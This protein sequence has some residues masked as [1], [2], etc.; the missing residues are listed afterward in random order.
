MLVAQ[1]NGFQICFSGK[2]SH[3]YIYLLLFNLIVV[4][5]V[6]NSNHGGHI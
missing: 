6:E 5:E 1:K 4:K 2:K 3:V